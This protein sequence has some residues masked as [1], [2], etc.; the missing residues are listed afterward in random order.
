MT[1]RSPLPPIHMHSSVILAGSRLIIRVFRCPR[2]SLSCFCAWSDMYYGA[3]IFQLVSR[4]N[5]VRNSQPR[6]GPRYSGSLKRRRI[7]AHMIT[8]AEKRVSTP[9]GAESD[10]FLLLLGVT[11]HT[12]LPA[13]ICWCLSQDVPGCNVQSRC[14]GLEVN[15][16]KQENHLRRGESKTPIVSGMS[17][18]IILLVNVGAH[19]VGWA[20]V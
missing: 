20:V 17:Q 18:T 3:N 6:V 9:I 10:L 14:A 7:S 2:A 15:E 1:M 19:T 12:T 13:A 11:L 8:W 16:R 5:F 4:K